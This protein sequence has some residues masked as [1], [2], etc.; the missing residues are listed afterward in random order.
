MRFL[1]RLASVR[2][3]VVALLALAGLGI[4]GRTAGGLSHGW[5]AVPAAALAVNLLAAL[6][7]N[8][9]LRAHRAL[10]LFHWALLGVALLIA[11]SALGR[12]EGRV[13]IVEGSAFDAEAVQVTEGAPFAVTRVA[14]VEFVQESLVVDY[15]PGLGRQ[16]LRSVVTTAEGSREVSEHG[17]LEVAGYRF[18]PTPNKG[19]AVLLTWRDASGVIA[20]GAVHLPSY[21]VYEW[22]QEADWVTPAGERVT[23]RFRPTE[24]A[25]MDRSW[26]LSRARATG[27]VTVRGERGEVELV[28]GTPA[29]LRGGVVVLEDLR[30]WVG[31]S[32]DHDPA[33]PWLFLVAAVGVLALVWYLLVEAPATRAVGRRRSQAVAD[34]AL[35]RV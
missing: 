12:F 25:P 34:G 9:R 16:Q 20:S 29:T 22:R 7:T 19:F 10:A 8:R 18:S 23:I 32:V 13:E 6:L 31:Y 24:R 5:M 17:A 30:L 11:V 14:G 27:T 35:G 1:T 26:T 21:P 2:F 4:A 3:T 33:M 28:P 15:L